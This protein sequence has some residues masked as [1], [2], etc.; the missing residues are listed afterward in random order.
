MRGNGG[1]VTDLAFEEEGEGGIGK[2][3]AD[4]ERLLQLIGLQNSGTGPRHWLRLVRLSLG[5]HLELRIRIYRQG[6]D[7]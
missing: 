3:G 7:Q 2:L 5:L 1:N 6:P 4:V